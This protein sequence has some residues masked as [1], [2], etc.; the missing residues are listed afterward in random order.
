MNHV[1]TRS[2]N[3]IV[4]GI[5]K[6]FANLILR[7]AIIFSNFFHIVL[8]PDHKVNEQNKYYSNRSDKVRFVLGIV[9]IIIAICSLRQAEYGNACLSIFFWVVAVISF[10]L[11]IMLFMVGATALSLSGMDCK[12]EE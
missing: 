12:S 4:G 7:R 11:G 10:I 1:V 5:F 3:P 6:V 9:T 8:M 2:Q